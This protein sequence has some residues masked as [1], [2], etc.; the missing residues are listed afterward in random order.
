MSSRG[1]GVQ[2][3]EHERTDRHDQRCALDNDENEEKRKPG[4]EEVGT[5]ITEKDRCA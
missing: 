3:I 2:Q 4:T 1:R 5:D